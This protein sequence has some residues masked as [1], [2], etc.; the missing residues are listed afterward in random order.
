MNRL[1][2]VGAILGFVL[3]LTITVV[4]IAYLLLGL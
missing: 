3:V 2:I 4:S 1:N